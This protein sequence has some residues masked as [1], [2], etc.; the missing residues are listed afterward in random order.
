MVPWVNCPLRHLPFGLAKPVAH[1]GALGLGRRDRERLQRVCASLRDGTARISVLDHEVAACQLLFR[2]RFSDGFRCANCPGTEAKQVNRRPRVWRCLTCNHHHSVTAGTPLHGLRTELNRVLRLLLL[3]GSLRCSAIEAARVLQM[4]YATVWEIWQKLRTALGAR[5]PEV[6]KFILYDTI[7]V[8]RRGTR[9]EPNPMHHIT[10]SA[11]QLAVAYAVDDAWRARTRSGTR[12]E[13]V[14]RE[15]L[16]QVTGQAVEN[17]PRLSCHGLP[18]RLRW[19][20]DVCHRSVSRRWVDRYLAMVTAIMPADAS[21]LAWVKGEL[22]DLYGWAGMVLG[23]QRRTA[24]DNVPPV[25]ANDWRYPR[26]PWVDPTCDV[27]PPLEVS[28][29]LSHQSQ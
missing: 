8:G 17:V 13:T 25:P 6:V 3:L 18:G 22:V 7:L 27:G 29:R 24:R 21:T 12:P 19:V 9:A 5:V 4:R 15:L 14:A 1:R 10:D 20:L 23:G 11:Q 16:Q 26:C 28:Q 2:L